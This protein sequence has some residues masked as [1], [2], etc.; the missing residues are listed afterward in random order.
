MATDLFI[1]SHRLNLHW[2]S[3]T[4]CGDED[5]KMTPF[6]SSLGAVLAPYRL[7]LYILIVPRL[8]VSLLF[9]SHPD[10]CDQGS[11]A[12]S[13]LDPAIPE[14]RVACLLHMMDV[15]C[16]QS[17]QQVSHQLEYGSIESS[18]DPGLQGPGFHATAT[19][20]VC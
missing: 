12:L 11:K 6:Y 9:Q 4:A 14:L 18:T 7:G 17:K 13:E 20:L 10:D 1:S 16:T 19:R 3:I 15:S 5:G 8:D 2:Q